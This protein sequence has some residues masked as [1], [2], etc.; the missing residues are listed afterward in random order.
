MSRAE[1]ERTN[2]RFLF[3]LLLQWART[4]AYYGRRWQPLSVHLE[5]YVNKV[6]ERGPPIYLRY[7]WRL[8]NLIICRCHYKDSTFSSVIFGL[9]SNSQPLAQQTGA[10]LTELNGR[11]T[12]VISILIQENEMKLTYFSLHRYKSRIFWVACKERVILIPACC[13]SIL[14]YCHT[15]RSNQRNLAVRF[16]C[17]VENF[18]ANAR[19]T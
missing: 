19:E 13:S 2:I 17:L 3:T 11:R 4:S 14:I 12:N 18:T 8:E 6:C 10:L 7:P 1:S 9:D 5:L 16:F 15:Q